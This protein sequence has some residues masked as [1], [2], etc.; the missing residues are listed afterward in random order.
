MEFAPSCSCCIASYLALQMIIAFLLLYAGTT[1]M[2]I[3]KKSTIFWKVLI[4]ALNI[5]LLVSI[6]IT[7][8]LTQSSDFRAWFFSRLFFYISNIDKPDP[9][10]CALFSNIKGRVLELGPGPGTNFK[11]IVNNTAITEWV[12]VEPNNFFRDKQRERIEKMKL[13]YP[14]RTVWLKG[15][16]IDIEPGTFDHVIGTHVLCSVNSVSDVLRQVSRALKPSGSYIFFEHVLSANSDS[17]RYWQELFS[18]L[19]YYVGNGCQFRDLERE[20]L[21]FFAGFENFHVNVTR[22]EAAVPIP[23]IRPH[24]S[25]SVLK[26]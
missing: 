6:C 4:V 14:A 21:E 23:V 20:I 18:P 22:L 26:I 9:T 19:F 12:G 2:L 24:I 3:T 5:V 25:G 7:M 13:G 17:M 16:D 15:E 8:A 1:S 10:R 11:C